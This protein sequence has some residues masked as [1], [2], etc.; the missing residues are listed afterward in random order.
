MICILF[1]VLLI[2]YSFIALWIQNTSHA[3][4]P[5]L[6]FIEY[7]FLI[8]A[9]FLSSLLLKEKA[10][11][12][13]HVNLRRK[14]V[15]GNTAYRFLRNFSTGFFTK[16]AIQPSMRKDKVKM[17]WHSLNSYKV[18]FKEHHIHTHA[19]AFLEVQAVISA[20]M[21]LD[22]DFQSFFSQFT[23]STSL[24]KHAV[25]GQCLIPQ[26][27]KILIVPLSFC[28]L[29]H[30]PCLSLKRKKEINKSHVMI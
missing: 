27:Q 6:E 11:K 28:Q 13:K 7:S 8:V 17:A 16:A 10:L 14:T 5:V 26:D 22:F 1:P 23:R 29:C 2:I 4:T 25:A 18:S 12:I 9:L 3:I 19:K 24:L 15:D 21:W 20:W 30:I